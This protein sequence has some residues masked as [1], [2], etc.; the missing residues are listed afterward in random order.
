MKKRVFIGKV[1][2]KDKILQKGMVEIEEGKISYVGRRKKVDKDSEVFYLEDF[3]I[4]PGFIDIH[5]HGAYGRDFLN[6]SFKDMEEISYFLASKGV[7]SCL[8]TL[9]TSSLPEMK[10]AISEI[11]SYISSNVMKGTKF[12]GIHLEGPFLNPNY[13]GAQK[14]DAILKP[15]LNILN[16]LLS[17]H[18][19]L[20][21]LAPELEGAL[22]LI[23]YLS[24]KGVIISAGHTSALSQDM[25]KAINLGLSHITHLFN[26]MRPLHHRE[27]GIIGVALV[28][29][30]LSVEII[31]DG[32][33]LSNYI[34]KLVTRIKPRDKVVLITDAIMAAGL[35]DGEYSLAGQK[36]LV[37][38]GKATLESG[39]LAGSTLTMNRAIKNMVEKEIVSLVD[40]IYMASLSPAKVIGI[41]GRKGSLEASKDAD[42]TVLDESFNVKL[43]MVEG[44]IIY[45]AL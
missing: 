1:I 18:V 22:E 43:T 44:H 34:L 36:V 38:D 13:K 31:A 16:E 3:Y 23:S 15:D 30:R 21:T 27:P 25:E 40:A 2:L 33:H 45:N 39:S 32:Y 8:P 41:D 4:S 20:I 24:K 6:S 26:G 17:S 5:I 37:K 29:D 10:K 14:E 19:R 7:T 11:E 42:L 12:I 28:D 35:S 9:A